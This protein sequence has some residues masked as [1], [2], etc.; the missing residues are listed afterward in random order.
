MHKYAGVA[1]KWSALFLIVMAVLVDSPVLFYMATA[2]LVTIGAARLQAHLAVRYLRFE[3]HTTPA[4]KV[5][6]IV[7][8]EI[9]IW[10]ER[11][12]KRPLVTVIDNIPKRLKIRDRTDCISVAPSFDQPISTRYSFRPMRRGRFS[13][14][15]L[16]LRGTDALGLVTVSKVH[17]TEPVNLVVYPAPL[18]FPHEIPAGMGWGASDLDSGHSRGSGL[19]PR[20]VR[21]YANGDPLR[22]VHWRSSARRGKLMVKEFETGSGVS[23]NLVLQRTRGSEVG[24]DATSTFETMCGHALTIADDYLS[25]GAAVR[26]P[27][28]EGGDTHLEHAEVRKR[29]V[30]EVLTDINADSL[31]KISEDL[32]MVAP[33]LREGETVVVLLAQADHDL[34]AALR[35][36]AAVQFVCVLYN[37]LEFGR[38]EASFGTPATDPEYIDALERAGA[39]VIVTSRSERHG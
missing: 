17:Q 22:Y 9:L 36:I 34:P 35:H 26:F 39:V 15:Q 20:G 4:V 14:S 3:R 12:L 7:N 24:N 1:L 16:T 10:S 18:P 5:G 33:Q 25:K 30:K 2:I 28:Q 31:T 23:L 19:E 6:E 37:P 32:M 11:E 29:E 8:M 13:W 38:P 21:E 27:L